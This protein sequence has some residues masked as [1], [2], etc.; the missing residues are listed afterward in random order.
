[1]LWAWKH[2]PEMAT[3]VQGKLKKY[4]N[5][6]MIDGLHGHEMWLVNGV[7]PPWKKKTQNAGAK[8]NSFNP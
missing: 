3:V 2:N 4:I 5:G 6:E 8:K 1:M 7:Q